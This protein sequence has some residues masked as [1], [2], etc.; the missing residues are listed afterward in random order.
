MDSVTSHHGT[1][2]GRRSE[3]WGRRNAAAS[4]KRQLDLEDILNPPG[5]G[6]ADDEDDREPP[7]R[8]P[9]TNPRPDPEEEEEDV[10]PRG[11]SGPGRRES[12]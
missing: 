12:I 5:R 11:G 3:H 4:A 6:D 9:P 1:K 10:P 8:D 2:A 7:I